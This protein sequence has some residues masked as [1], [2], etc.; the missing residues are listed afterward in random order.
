MHI[1]ELAQNPGR[2]TSCP[3]AEKRTEDTRRPIEMVCRARVMTI[4]SSYRGGWKVGGGCGCGFG[5]DVA[6]YESIAWCKNMRSGSGTCQRRE[7]IYT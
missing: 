1:N 3:S 5:V 6:V 7:A 2:P 4:A